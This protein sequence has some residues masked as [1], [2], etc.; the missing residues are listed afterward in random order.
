MSGGA[1]KD[2]SMMRIPETRNRH[3]GDLHESTGPDP[4]RQLRRRY[5][6]H[7]LMRECEIMRPVCQRAPHGCRRNV[8]VDE[9]AATRDT[10]RRLQERLALMVGRDMMHHVD[11]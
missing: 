10:A 3:G 4:L 7:P 11:H 2:D 6:V 9:H 8:L 5:I 1:A